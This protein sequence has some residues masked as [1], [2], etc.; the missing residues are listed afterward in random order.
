MPKYR[1]NPDT[2]LYEEKNE[3]KYLKHIKIAV[4]VL[5]AAGFVFLY[6]WLYTS[7]FH[8]DLPKTA[9]LKRRAAEWEAKMEVLEG[10]L[11]LYDR[12]LTGIEQRDDEVYR[13]IYGLGSIPDEV[14]NSGL[15]GQNR[16]AELD[17]LGTNSDLGW[18]VRWLDNLTKRVYVRSKALD[19]VGQLAR[20]AGDMISCVPSVPPLAPDPVKVHLSSGF[21]YRTDPVYGGG[22]NHGGQ[23][24]ATS[25]GTPVYSTG[26]GVVIQAEYKSNGY[27]NQIVIDHGYGYQTRYAHLSVISVVEGMQVKR[28]ELIGKVGNTGKSTGPHL[29]YEVVYRGNRVNPMNYM[30]FKMPVDEYLSMTEQRR[31]DS[32]VGKRSSTTELLRRSRR[33]TDG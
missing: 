20:N 11:D 8:W 27:G 23:D 19:E 9:I 2:L 6:F 33:N 30:D 5:A 1:F 31:E 29:H 28:G 24:F 18:T 13:S 10:R 17:R 12:T 21:G 32:P 16:Y 26:D 22:E 4:A 14:K 25:I 3:F 15:G 7:V